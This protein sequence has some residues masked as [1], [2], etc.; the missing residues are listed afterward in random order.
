MTGF[1]EVLIT[2]GAFVLGLV[3]RL[4]LVVLLV[5]VIAAPVLLALEA[6]RRFA[7]LRQRL[8]GLAE[9]AG[10]QWRSGVHYARSHTWLKREDPGTVR[11]GVCGLV[12]RLL[13]GVR[14]VVLPVP[15]QTVQRGEKLAEIVSDGRHVPIVA[16]L[17]GR[18][19]RVNPSL[20]RR[21]VL[22][23]QDPY[24]RGWLVAIEPKQQGLDELPRNQPARDWMHAESLRLARFFEHD[25]GLAAADGGE[26]VVPPVTALSEER[27][28]ALAQEFLRED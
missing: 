6:G 7:A 3:V 17:D 25:L 24:V 19:T 15:G 21:P 11:V 5:A 20:A 4:A 27:F 26:Y 13:H 2:A 16:P 22:V 12:Q 14:E 9:V 18:I 1:T 28:R 23:E 10:L 8:M